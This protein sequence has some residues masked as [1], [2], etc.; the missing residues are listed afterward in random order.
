M[1]KGDSEVKFSDRNCRADCKTYHVVAA[2]LSFLAVFLIGGT[3]YPEN[4]GTRFSEIR[5]IFLSCD[6][7][8]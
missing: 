6:A 3:R 8:F 2:E 1:L 4:K 5:T 7:E